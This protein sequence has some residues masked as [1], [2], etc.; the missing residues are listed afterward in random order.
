MPEYASHDPNHV[1]CPFHAL[2]GLEACSPCCCQREIC[3]RYQYPPFRVADLAVY[4]VVYHEK[5]LQEWL[6]EETESLRY[7]RTLPSVYVSQ[8][9]LLRL[10]AL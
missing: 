9:D 4:L 3:H 2:Y 7:C 10:G 1:A 5:G 8:S 6:L